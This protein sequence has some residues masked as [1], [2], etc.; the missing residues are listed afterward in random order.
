[1]AKIVIPDYVLAKMAQAYGCRLDQLTYFAGGTDGSDGIL[2]RY[3]DEGQGK[4][5]KLMIIPDT[6]PL[7]VERT[8]ERVRFTHYL[9]ER[10]V[11]TIY[12]RPSINGELVERLTDGDRRYIAYTMDQINGTPF[13]KINPDRLDHYIVQWGKTIGLLHVCTQGYDSPDARLQLNW[14]RE[15][16]SFRDWCQD[17]QVRAIWEELRQELSRYTPTRESYGM[18]H[19][20]PHPWN[21][22]LVDDR[23]ALLDF[24]VANQH[25][26]MTD[27]AI[28]IFHGLAWH[29]GGINLP[30]KDKD[31]P[32]RLLEHWL[33][34]Y[35]QHH[36]LSREWLDRLELF[37]RYRRILTFIVFYQGLQKQPETLQHWRN[38]IL[39][40]APIMAT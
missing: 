35:Q 28:A 27:I 17:E 23:V 12:P 16:D 3:E 21:T 14:Q 1:M 18:I 19:N 4:L 31:F 7:G 34:G 40:E 5:L 32:R 26:F 2:Y 13:A 30:P 6:E 36:Q 10:G 38:C 20:D 24:D 39:T 25:W 22:M 37:M 33:T 9:A 29:T 8:M 15:M 11:P